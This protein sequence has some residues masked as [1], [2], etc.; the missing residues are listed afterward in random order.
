M[1]LSIPTNIKH[2][3]LLRH[4]SKKGFIAQSL[5]ILLKYVFFLLHDKFSNISANI[6]LRLKVSEN[7]N[8]LA[9]LNCEKKVLLYKASFSFEIIYFTSI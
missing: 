5:A 4:L 9:Y 6:K 2:S 1:V 8:T 7:E 3:S